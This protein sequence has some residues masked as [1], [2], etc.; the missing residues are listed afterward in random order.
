MEISKFLLRTTGLAIGTVFKSSDADIRVHGEDNVPDGP[1]LYVANHFTRMETT[2][3]P[4]VI[5]RYTKKYCISL[6][7]F[8]FFGGTFGKILSKLG[9]LSTK[10]PD[11]DKILISTLLKGEISVII[12][13]EG[14]MIKDKKIIE[15]GKYMVFNAGIRR[16]PHSGAARLALRSEFYREKMR[17]FKEIGF[18][19]GLEKY[20][21][22]FEISE[23]EL[24]SVLALETSIVPINVTYYPIRAKNNAI[25][26]LVERFVKNVSD[27]FEEEL[28]VEGTMVMDGVDIDINFGKPIPINKFTQESDTGKGIKNMK[29]YLSKAELNEAVPFKKSGLKITQSYMDSIY[30]MTTLNHDHIFAHILCDCPRSKISEDLL[31][32]RAFLAV[33]KV[34]D[35]N[36]TNCHTTLNK[37]QFHLLTDDEHKT[38]ESFIE[39]AVSDGLITVKD[40][41]IY[42]SKERFQDAYKFH[43]IRKD[44]IVEVLKNEIEP[45]TEV[46][47]AI[48]K[49]MILPKWAIHRIIRNRFFNLDLDLFKQDY[50][51]YH[52]INESKS[53]EIGRPFFLRKSYQRKGVILIHG[54]MAAPEEVRVVAEALHK[55]GY[56]VYGVRLR[57]HGTAPEDLGKREWYDWYNS[58]NRAYIVMN[59]TVDKISIVGFSTGAGL[60]L[61]Q[62]ANK[63]NNFRGVVSINAPLKLQNISSQLSSAVVVWNNLL[64]RMHVNKG[65]MEFVTN[66]PENK[67]INYFRN[68]IS[69]VAQLEKLMDKVEESLHKIEIPALIIQ[70]SDDPVVNPVSGKEIF[71]KLGTK[72]KEIQS[73]YAERHGIVRGEES[74]KVISHV[75]DFLDEVCK[76]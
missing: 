26:K 25:K 6:A 9:G 37:N 31:K 24:D 33:E 58:V 75:L 73:I 40:G 65:K 28:E 74:K 36:I 44:N 60:A 22:Y 66:D 59:H 68:P 16:P 63:G 13:P 11:R 32:A 10:D 27:R 12:F 43:T 51:K 72:K 49:V 14:Q 3:M 67:H 48:R 30:N 5:E 18:R 21:S 53:P 35:L 29:T 57:G 41:F 20:M 71:D 47:K 55:K 23:E 34:K 46:R 54:Y 4:Y 56:V 69:G 15:K 17:H 70:G 2:F 45:M 64:D 42:K 1:V 7:H 76:D 38:Y 19:E 8:S 61:L 50:D 52:I 62:A 39:A